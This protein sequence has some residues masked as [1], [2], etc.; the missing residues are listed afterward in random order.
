MPDATAYKEAG[1]VTKL[2]LRSVGET[3]ARMVA[4]VDAKAM[5]LF[6]VID[7][8]AEAHKVGLVLRETRA[9]RTITCANAS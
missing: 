1:A 3:V 2:S 5:T 6:A 7:Q 4:L 9:R 8:R